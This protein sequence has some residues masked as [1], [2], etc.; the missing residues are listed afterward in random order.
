MSNNEIT[1]IDNKIKCSCKGYNLDRL[2][3]PRILIILSNNKMHGYSIIQKLEEKDFGNGKAD[4]TGIY[5]TLNTMESKGL[6]KFQ[7]DLESSAKK[8]YEITDVGL[9]CLNE[10]EKTLGLYKDFISNILIQLK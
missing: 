1:L 4:N 6:I 8:V 7:W 5:R 2:L 9:E 3:Q 10:W